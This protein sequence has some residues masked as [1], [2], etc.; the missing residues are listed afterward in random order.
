[1]RGAARRVMAAAAAPA[2]AEEA[3]L[4]LLRPL[5]RCTKAAALGVC[6]ARGLP[7]ASD[8][9]N[10][11]AVYD[12]VRARAAVAALAAEGGGI[13]DLLAVAARMARHADELDARCDEALASL[14]LPPPPAAA[15]ALPA[16]GAPLRISAA[17]WQ[18]ATRALPAL[19]RTAAARRLL[20]L[21]GGAAAPRP[22]EDRHAAR[23]ARLFD[24]LAAA[25]AAQAARSGGFSGDA[26]T[27]SGRWPSVAIQD[28]LATV[29]RAAGG[30]GEVAYDV[31]LAP[32]RRRLPDR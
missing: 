3:P 20:Q 6:A 14:L 11:N 13:D 8:P 27:R 10:V 1:M 26:P 12:R 19:V 28:A 7:Y 17:A 5:L 31:L 4:L 16:A 23:L 18:R 21:A 29:V 25:A 15:A 30:G 9:S 2:D 22:L 32:R 24:E